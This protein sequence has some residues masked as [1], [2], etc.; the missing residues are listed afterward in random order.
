MNS[1]YITKCEEIEENWPYD[2]VVERQKRQTRI[3]QNQFCAFCH[4]LKLPAEQDTD[5][6]H[7]DR[8]SAHPEHVT[9]LRGES[10]LS[11]LKPSYNCAVKTPTANVILHL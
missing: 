11:R 1:I 4:G 5:P 7:G 2:I 8:L 9:A 10:V 6:L 3:S